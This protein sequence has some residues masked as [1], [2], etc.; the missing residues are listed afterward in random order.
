MDKQGHADIRRYADIEIER[1]RIFPPGTELTTQEAPT[2]LEVTSP[3]DFS[4]PQDTELTVEEL[5]ARRPRTTILDG[6][7][8]KI[9]KIKPRG[10]NASQ[11]GTKLSVFLNTV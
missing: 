5:P 11:M 6:T 2:P 9:R 8:R 7:R 3:Q 1:Y 10:L 4:V